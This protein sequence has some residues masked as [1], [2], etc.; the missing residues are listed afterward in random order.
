MD[1]NWAKAKAEKMLRHQ[2]DII[3]RSDYPDREMA[4]GMVQL[5]YALDLLTDDGMAYW[6]HRV[7]VAVDR[8]RQEL[9]NNRK[10]EL[11]VAG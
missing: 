3:G 10:T 5:A 4:E 1:T 6:Q 11:E 7:Q 8:R 9:R 2:V